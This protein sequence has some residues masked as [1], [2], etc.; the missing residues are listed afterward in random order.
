MDAAMAAVLSELDEFF[1]L[2]RQHG[3]MKTALKASLVRQ[4][5]ST[6]ILAGSGK[7]AAAHDG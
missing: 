7:D 2:K 1:T 5:V 4:H 6:L 3:R